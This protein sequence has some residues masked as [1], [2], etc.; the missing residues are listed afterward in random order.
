MQPKHLT[1]ICR[2]GVTLKR[3]VRGGRGD[4][5]CVCKV[6]FPETE[7]VC[8]ASMVASVTRT[9]ASKPL[10]THKCISSAGCRRGGRGAQEVGLLLL[11]APAPMSWV[12]L[13]EWLQGPVLHLPGT[14]PAT[15]LTWGPVQTW[16]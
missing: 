10:K 5:S 14:V 2:V 8:E 9:A 3:G 15:Q 13:S 11:L 1:C 7:K 6:L 16:L 12:I 4:L